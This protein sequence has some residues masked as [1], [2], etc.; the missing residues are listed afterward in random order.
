M[1]SGRGDPRQWLATISG[2]QHTAL[3]QGVRVRNVMNPLIWYISFSTPAGVAVLI[4]A[5][6]YKWLG[7]ALLVSD[8]I[9]L[10]IY[11]YWMFTAPERLQN[12]DYRLGALAVTAFGTQGHEVDDPLILPSGNAT[13]PGSP[14]P[15]EDAGTPADWGRG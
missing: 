14:L 1:T 5:A 15:L 8:F 10:A 13:P 12:E 7:V 6:V 3:A 4:F 2:N 11:L 9:F